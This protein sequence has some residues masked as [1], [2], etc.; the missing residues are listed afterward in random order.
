MST[1]VKTL[2]PAS[3]HIDLTRFLTKNAPTPSTTKKLYKNPKTEQVSPAKSLHQ[4]TVAAGVKARGPPDSMT[5][6]LNYIIDDTRPFT[7][8]K[9]ENAKIS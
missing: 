3:Q 4:Q 5:Q 2:L 6:I 1:P 7:S 9:R 8:K